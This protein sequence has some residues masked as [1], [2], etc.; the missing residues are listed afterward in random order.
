MAQGHISSKQE[1]FARS[2]LKAF[3]PNE[4]MPEPIS[5]EA[6]QLAA[7]ITAAVTQHMNLMS[8]LARF[9]QDLS[10]T[11]KKIVFKVIP[12]GA[13]ATQVLNWFLD[14]RI[15]AFWSQYKTNMTRTAYQ[16]VQL[17]YKSHF[18]AVCSGDAD[19]YRILSR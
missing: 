19:V 15:E 1:A 3:F 13:V 11:L 10:N 5:A 12:V 7:T 17:N 18:L 8:E 2:V 16:W 4:P 9:G 6:V 14:P